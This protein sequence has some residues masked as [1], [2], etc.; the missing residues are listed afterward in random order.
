MKGFSLTIVLILTLVVMTQQVYAAGEPQVRFLEPATGNSGPNLSVVVDASDADGKVREVRLYINNIQVRRE[1]A[2]PYEWGMANPGQND[3]ALLN[4]T[5]GSYQLRAVAKDNQNKTAS[6]TRTIA[7]LGTNSTPTSSARAVQNGET[8]LKLDDSLQT[9]QYLASSNGAYRLNFQ[10]DGNLVLRDQATGAALW[11]SKTNGQNTT[12]LT[13]QGDGNLVL[14]SS[15]G[16]AAWS[17]KTNGTGAVKAVMQND[18]NFVIYTASNAAVWSTDTAQTLDIGGTDN[19]GTDTGGTDTGGGS[20]SNDGGGTGGNTAESTGEFSTPSAAL[21]SLNSSK[22]LGFP[23]HIDTGFE[24]NGHAESWD[25]RFFVRTRTAGWFASAFRPERIARNSDG[26]V[27]FK[28]GAFGNSIELELKTDEPSMQHNWLAIVPDFSVSGENPY[29]SNSS[30]SYQLTG[31]HRTYRALVYHTTTDKQMGI[32]KATFIISSANTRDAQLIKADFTNSFSRLRLQSGGDFRCIEPSVTIDGRLVV[33]QGHPNNDGKIDNLVY[34]YTT[35]PGSTSN[36]TAPK[37]IANM[38]FDDRNT[39]IEG[40]T[41][42]E[43][44]PV[45]QQAILDSSGNDYNRGELI[46]GAYPWISRDGTEIFYQASREGISSARRAGTSVVGRW[47]G[48]AIRH[49]DGPI[50]G[51][52]KKTSR[53]FLSSPGAFTTM[54]TPYKDIAN[55]AIPY[56]LQGPVYPIFGSNTSDYSE[57]GFDDYLD[58]NYVMY[59][60]MNELLDRAGSYKVTQTNDTSGHFNNATLVGA[61]FPIEFNGQ[62]IMA[63]RYGQAIHFNSNN[64][65]N[66]TKNEGWNSLADGVSVDMWVRKSLGTGRVR[67]FNMQNGVELNL[68]NGSTLSASIHDTNS[69]LEQINGSS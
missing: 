33:C 11:S 16:S 28:Q 8:T 55:L 29:P 22:Q 53:L 18:G 54:W 36:W 14:Y 61:R 1:R 34:S 59:L 47:T 6:A 42:A 27:D 39:N 15:S 12:R 60:G 25:G 32:R 3:S 62:D 68:I 26:S 57:I 9:N 19:G 13:M 50:N 64:Y 43:R 41:F 44:Y 51:D 65:L 21:Y 4:L 67:L 63:G 45:A 46:K 30:G 10:R 17:S 23:T 69:N 7:V 31:S 2:A 58:G 35:I 56:S 38:Y 52:R 20:G 66:V 48:W 37:S 5:P 24:G 49:I 40:L